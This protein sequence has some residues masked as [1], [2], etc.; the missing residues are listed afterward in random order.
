MMGKYLLQ[1][2]HLQYYYRYILHF[3]VLFINSGYIQV[4]I[5]SERKEKKLVQLGFWKADVPN[6]R[7]RV[8]SWLSM[9]CSSLNIS[10]NLLSKKMW[11][12]I[13]L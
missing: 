2:L 11:I 3:F 5:I 1:N 6:V 8:T 10:L 4:A 12:M 7:G 13:P 9:S